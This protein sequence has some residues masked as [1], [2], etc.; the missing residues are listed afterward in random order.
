M[1]QIYLRQRKLE[2]AEQQ[3]RAGV[4]LAPE[5]FRPQ[6]S[7]FFMQKFRS[8]PS[9]ASVETK[10]DSLINSWQNDWQ[11]VAAFQEA[12]RLYRQQDAQGQQLVL[13]ALQQATVLINRQ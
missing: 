9:T 8:L 12:I 4:E 5:V 3:L 6:L 13:E 1:A 11:N 10:L 7:T 2:L